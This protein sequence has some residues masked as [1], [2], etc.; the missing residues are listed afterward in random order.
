MVGCGRFTGTQ[1]A[2]LGRIR[3]NHPGVIDISTAPMGVIGGFQIIP[4]DHSMSP[5]M[6]NARLLTQWMVVGPLYALDESWEGSEPLFNDYLYPCF[7]PAMKADG[8]VN[9]EIQ[10]AA[11]FLDRFT[12]RGRYSDDP[13][14]KKY[15]LLHPAEGKTDD[16]FKTLTH[17][18]IFFPRT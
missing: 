10:G 2:D 6:T 16:A 9:E 4:R 14:P 1:Y 13:D 7:T 5:E 8:T 17:I 18:R 3:A 15:V 11:A 12:V